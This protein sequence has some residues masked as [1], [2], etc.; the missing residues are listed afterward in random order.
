MV[1]FA[2]SEK[3]F[4]F[5]PTSLRELVPDPP[6]THPDPFMRDCLSAILYGHVRL[7]FSFE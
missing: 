1:L 2:L 6:F 7:H 3:L 4:N 5:L